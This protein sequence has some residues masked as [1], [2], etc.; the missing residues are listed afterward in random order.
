MR[1]YLDISQGFYKPEIMGALKQPKAERFDLAQFHKG[2]RVSKRFFGPFQIAYDSLVGKPKES[3][4]D[5]EA[6]DATLAAATANADAATAEAAAPK[7][8]IK[9]TEVT[10]MQLSAFKSACEKMCQQEIETRVV[11]LIAEGTD[12]E[13]RATLTATRLYQNPTEA[14]TARGFYDVKHALGDFQKF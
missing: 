5:A 2:N 6:A 4:Q 3:S 10:A 12:I 11:M 9:K 1:H 8:K 14:A 7:E 13:I